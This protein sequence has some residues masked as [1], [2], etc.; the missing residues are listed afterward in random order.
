MYARD[1]RKRFENYDVELVELPTDEYRRLIPETNKPGFPMEGRLTP[2]EK[3]KKRYMHEKLKDG[4]DWVL[5]SD[6]D[7]IITNW[8]FDLKPEWTH[9]ALLLNEMSGFV[10]VRDCIRHVYRFVNTVGTFD[11]AYA[12]KDLPRGLVSQAPIGY[13]FHMC[14]SSPEE[15]YWKFMNRT[16]DWGYYGNAPPT[17]E[18]GT[19]KIKNYLPNM[20]PTTNP[21]LKF[22]GK[23]FPVPTVDNVVDLAELPKFIREN[24][25]LFPHV[26]VQNE[27]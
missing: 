14:C 22:V 25:R 16:D 7:E 18:E 21:L 11:P 6:T 20:V 17:L 4:A 12:A 5:H 1:N 19:H 24:I 2:Q 15:Y 26:E 8:A 27:V 3:I 10:N 13:H 23:H 9:A